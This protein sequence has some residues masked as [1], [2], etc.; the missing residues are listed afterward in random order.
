MEIQK[1]IDQTYC[2]RTCSCSQRW[3]LADNFDCLLITFSTTSGIRITSGKMEYSIPTMKYGFELIVTTRIP[4]PDLFNSQ[5]VFRV[6]KK[7]KNSR[8]NGRLY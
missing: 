3:N 6:A 1:G 4:F 2:S 7:P 5:V 8:V